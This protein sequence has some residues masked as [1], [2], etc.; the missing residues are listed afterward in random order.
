L[1]PFSEYVSLVVFENILALFRCQRKNVL[2]VSLR[3]RLIAWA[4]PGVTLVTLGAFAFAW[5][6]GQSVTRQ[7]EQLWQSQVARGRD[8]LKGHERQV[9][10]AVEDYAFWDELVD[11]VAAAPNADFE[12]KSLGPWLFQS[13]GIDFVVVLDVQSRVVYAFDP[14]G[15]FRRG[16]SFEDSPVIRL[17]TE[18]PTQLSLVYLDEAPVWVAGGTIHSTLTPDYEPPGAGTLLLGRALDANYLE[19]LYDQS[20]LRVELATLRDLSQ[21]G[22]AAT[23]DGR[24]ARGVTLTDA[25]GRPAAELTLVSDPS[26]ASTSVRAFWALAT[27][28]FAVLLLGL[29]LL[30]IAA[31]RTLVRPLV[32]LR[33]A[34]RGLRYGEPVDAKLSTS[35]SDELGQ[36]AR[37]FA[38][39]AKDLQSSELMLSKSEDKRLT[40][41][42]GVP[43]TILLVGSDG[44]ILEVKQSESQFP[45]DLSSSVGRCVTDVLPAIVA[46]RTMGILRESTFGGRTTCEFALAHNET[47]AHFEARVV[48]S[49]SGEA[50]VILRDVTDAQPTMKHFTPM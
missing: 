41:L 12:D 33:D 27:Y 8:L 45:V 7:E 1:F 2:K 16:E 9:I 37:E 47:T 28:F 39:L 14:T 22:K 38:T 50:V 19:R 43:D 18:R 44:I 21:G 36:V 31:D 40:L 23:T 10:Q 34:I 17:A 30:V 13:F 29:G 49:G 32:V 26:A 15:F 11:Y 6:S 20:G 5:F 3:G 48:R 42:L 4:M 46:R 25:R 24:R 35:R